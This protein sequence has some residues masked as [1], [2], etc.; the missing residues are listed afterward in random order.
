MSNNRG[1]PLYG[2]NT[3]SFI[4]VYLLCKNA[5]LIN[6]ILNLNKHQVP[7]KIYAY[8]LLGIENV[9]VDLFLG[10]FLKLGYS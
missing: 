6:I 8:I 3:S 9:Y 4:S 2:Q 5:R 10:S 1:L 7:N